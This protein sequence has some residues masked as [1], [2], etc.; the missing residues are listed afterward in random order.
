MV[1]LLW[2]RRAVGESSHT[3]RSC[4]ELEQPAEIDFS[5]NSR[6]YI[7]LKLPRDHTSSSTQCL[8]SI[9][10][11]VYLHIACL[12]LGYRLC[13]SSFP[14][15]TL[16]ILFTTRCICQLQLPNSLLVNAIYYNIKNATIE[17]YED[18]K[19]TIKY[20][21]NWNFPSITLG[22]I[23]LRLDWPTSVRLLFLI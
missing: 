17:H 19:M 16:L 5:Q 11:G 6:S 18:V 14:V 4:W 1:L 7:Y 22:D 13:I 23:Y 12:C 3:Q 8:F 20:L 21:K 10:H 15:V 2:S 9:S